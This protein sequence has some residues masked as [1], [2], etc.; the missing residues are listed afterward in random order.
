MK[1]LQNIERANENNFLWSSI[2]D[3]VDT[4][5][6]RREHADAYERIW[7]L[8]HI[9]EAV[10]TTLSGAAVCRLRHFGVE[11]ET[12]YLKVREHLFGVTFDKIDK[13]LK[14]GQGALDGSNDKRIEVLRV[15]QKADG[16]TSEFLNRLKLLLEWPDGVT[17]EPGS[18]SGSENRVAARKAS[19]ALL[20]VWKRVCDVPGAAE[21]L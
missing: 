16:F 1:E 6:R 14:A 4:F 7:R 9:W 15:I 5:L 13:R 11:A 3:A 18:D 12:L 21:Q 19:A 17:D 2:A 8:I 10:T 20:D